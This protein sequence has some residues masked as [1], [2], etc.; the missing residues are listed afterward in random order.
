MAIKTTVIT[1]ATSGIGR[2]TALALA[3][4]DQAL[5]MLV[6]N[7]MKG[8]RLKEEIIATT[9][10]KDIHVIKCDLSDLQ[11][12]REAADELKSKL[13][14]VNVLINNAGGIFPKKELNKD[15]YE[16]TF[17][18]NHLGHFLLTLS[19][20]QLLEKG[21]ARVINVSSDAYKWGDADFDDIQWQQHKYSA[22]KA[23]G[24]SKLFNI[25]FTK[26]LAEKYADKGITSFA[27][28]PGVVRTEF[29]AGVTGF[30]KIL[31]WLA[32]PFMISP[33]KGAQTSIWLATEPGI[34]AKSS[35][36][37]IKCQLAKSS[38]LSWSEDNRNKLWDIS[39]KLVK[40]YLE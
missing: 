40:G 35:Q 37:F 6:R 36:Y 2:E 39:K 34:E 3:K 17:V 26:A 20:A 23:Y 29:G 18:T 30:K 11:S 10:N 12:V 8:E 9:G 13:D 21:Q 15:G 16:M 28:H 31:L 7:V 14:A 38:I 25:Y 4:K 5:W 19:I 22:S 32:K 24:R 1:G 33:E 27:L